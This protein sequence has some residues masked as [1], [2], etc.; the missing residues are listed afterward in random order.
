M[1]KTINIETTYEVVTVYIKE[2]DAH[3]NPIE[4]YDDD[5]E[6]DCGYDDETEALDEAKSIART[7]TLDD[8][9][10]TFV[11]EVV[12]ALEDGFPISNEEIVNIAT[13]DFI[14]DVYE[15]VKKYDRDAMKRT[16]DAI[17]GDSKAASLA[18]EVC[19]AILESDYDYYQVVTRVYFDTDEV[20]SKAYSL[21]DS[22]GLAG[23]VENLFKTT[24]NRLNLF[25]INYGERYGR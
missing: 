2:R 16:M 23:D 19:R 7:A 12:V 14:K 17:E 24:A 3:G 10:F 1:E 8:D 6:F 5:M 22:E 9:Y 13:F 4:Y 21:D 15:D 20:Y 25:P 11:R 18:R